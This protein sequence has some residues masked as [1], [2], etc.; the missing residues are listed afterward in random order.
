MAKKCYLYSKANYPITIKYDKKDLVIPPNA[1]KFLLD[2]TT[3]DGVPPPKVRKD[4][5]EGGT[6]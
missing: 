4:D 1:K 2:D 6:K 5:I 3:K